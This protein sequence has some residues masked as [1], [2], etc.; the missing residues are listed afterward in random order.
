MSLFVTSFQ[1]PA[2]AAAGEERQALLLE[3]HI[4]ITQLCRPFLALVSLLI[5]RLHK[6]Y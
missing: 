5:Q 6:L 1:G 3:T 4:R 2:M